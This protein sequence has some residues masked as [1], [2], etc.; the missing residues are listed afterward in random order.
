MHQPSFLSLCFTI[1]LE[2]ELLS[3]SFS[4]EDIEL[5]EE[6]ELF[7]SD[8]SPLVFCS[9]LAIGNSTVSTC[10]SVDSVRLEDEIIP[11]H[12]WDEVLVRVSKVAANPAIIA[13]SLELDLVMIH[14]AIDIHN[15]LL[16]GFSY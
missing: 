13:V 2:L 10:C 6:T 7:T 11:Q 4:L 8:S 15:T 14:I 1:S 3:L 9:L 5:S 12:P 16:L